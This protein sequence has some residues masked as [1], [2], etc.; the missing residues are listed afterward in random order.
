MSIS[1]TSLIQC[2]KTTLPAPSVPEVLVSLHQD[3]VVWKE[4]LNPEFLNKVCFQITVQENIQ[5]TD[6]SPARLALIALNQPLKAGINL[7]LLP[8]K[9]LDQSTHDY[10]N[11]VRNQ[12]EPDLAR[13]GVIALALA[14]RNRLTN[15]WSFLPDEIDQHT[16]FPWETPI[17]CLLGMI[18][19]PLS[20]LAALSSQQPSLLRSRLAIHAILSHPLERASQIDTLIAITNKPLSNFPILPLDMLDFLQILNEQA[21]DLASTFCQKI[22]AQKISSSHL[23]ISQPFRQSDILRETASTLLELEISRLAGDELR[24]DLHLEKLIAMR[25]M[26]AASLLAQTAS[27]RSLENNDPLSNAHLISDWNKMIELL[28]TVKPASIVEPFK[29][30][31]AR[32]LINAGNTTQAYSVLSSVIPG[33]SK[34]LFQLNALL[35]AAHKHGDEELTRQAGTQL[36]QI[37]NCNQLSQGYIAPH[38][39]VNPSQIANDLNNVG[40]S[41]NAMLVLEMALQQSP[42]QESWM[43]DLVELQISSSRFSEA[44]EIMQFLAGLHPKDINLR[45]RLAQMYEAY[46]NWSAALDEWISL[47]EDTRYSSQLEELDDLHALSSCALNAGRP[48]PAIHASQR[49][50]SLSNEDGL[51]YAF[52]GRAYAMKRDFVRGMEYVTQATQNSPNLSEGWLALADILAQQDQIHQAI[53]SLQTAN[54]I[55]PNNPRLLFSAGQLHYSCENLT[56]AADLIKQAVSLDPTNIH[57]HYTLGLAL[58]RLGH[59][60]DAIQELYRAY[61]ED[62]QNIDYASAYGAALLDAGNSHAALKPLT[63][64][65]QSKESATPTA[66]VNYARSVLNLHNDGNTEAKPSLALEAIKAALALDPHQPE[67]KGWYADALRTTGDLGA[68]FTI[69]QE[70]LETHLVH[71]RQWRERLSYGLGQTA[72]LLGRYDIAIASVQEAIATA[73]NNSKN[74]KLIAD[75]YLSSNLLED[76]LRAARTVLNLNTDNLVNLAWYA[77]HITRLVAHNKAWS[78]SG[79]QN[80]TKQALLEAQNALLQA[81]Q[82]APNRAELLIKLSKVQQ[83]AGNTQS[84]L[85]TMK[86]FINNNEE[87]SVEHLTAAADQMTSLGDIKGTIACLEKAVL[88]SLPAN[89]TTPDLFARLAKTYTGLGDLTSACN[90]LEQAI[91]IAPNVGSLYLERTN[92]LLT[93]GRIEDAFACVETGIS[94]ARTDPSLPRLYIMAACLYRL[95]GDL[96]SALAYIHKGL[97][98]YNGFEISQFNTSGVPL[99]DRLLVADLY[100]VGL[101]PLIAYQILKPEPESTGKDG[102]PTDKSIFEWIGLKMELELELGYT[103]DTQQ[104]KRIQVADSPPS[105]RWLAI[106]TRL[107][108]LQGTNDQANQYFQAAIQKELEEN[109]A[110]S[111]H[112]GLGRITSQRS[113]VSLF[114]AALDY[115]D[116]HLAQDILRRLSEIAPDEP[117]THLAEVRLLVRQAEFQQVCSQLEVQ[118]HAPGNEVISLANKEILDDAI[119]QISNL[120][121]LIEKNHPA[122]DLAHPITRLERWHSRGQIAFSQNNGDIGDPSLL[123]AAVARLKINSPEQT[124]TGEDAAAIISALDIRSRQGTEDNLLSEILQLARPHSRNPWVWLQAALSLESN[125]PREAFS[126]ARGAIQLF[127]CKESP[128]AVLNQALLA[129]IALRL[130]DITVAQGAIEAALHVWTDEPRWHV[131][132]AQIYQANLRPVEGRKHLEIAAHLDPQGMA[133]QLELGKAYLADNALDS[134]NITK[135]IQCFDTAIH[136]D[137]TEVT[138]WIW[139]ARAQLR[140]KQVGDAEKSVRQILALAPDNKDASVLQAEIA[141]LKKS[142]QVAHTFAQ[143]AVQSN[144]E[145][146]K[147]TLLLARTLKSLN[148]PTEALQVIESAL[149][150]SRDPLQLQYERAKY[151]HELHGP[152]AALQVLTE[153][154]AAY[155]DD[156]NIL[157][158]L[159]RSQADLGDLQAATDTALIALKAGKAKLEPEALARA[160]YLAGTLLR[161]SGQLDQAIQ[162]LNEAVSLAP[163]FLEAYLELGVTRKE[164]REYQ[165]ALVAFE[166]AVKIAPHDY[167]PHYQAGL[168]LKEGKDYRRSEIMLRQAA[169]LAPD[170]VLVRRQLAQVVAL[171]VV[172]NPRT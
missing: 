159:A 9:L 151:L 36:T 172:H 65:I 156:A 1:L 82:L 153:L 77:D 22:N 170:D 3:R 101:Q 69:Y 67:I 7:E 109:V 117:F 91:S 158:S 121:H 105:S 20:M 83:I 23:P 39:A 54:Q 43:K 49:A 51:A 5:V 10:I 25:N 130:N 35:L 29:A 103:P 16:T 149:P 139:L 110:K 66:Y 15:S 100:R 107:E 164:R 98:G 136:L 17:V 56:L 11:L 138:A 89:T 88:K 42:N 106:Q 111:S 75:A 92:L 32:A 73:P 131:L 38:A 59:T 171:N 61:Q 113:I 127:V 40:M 96:A 71:D 108:L 147:T 76:S 166:Q 168:A 135:A 150:I 47:N 21:P 8:A 34:D 128:S 72:Y 155:P 165:Q 132:A 44:A 41:S 161:R 148:R 154:V 87:A 140:A 104:Y 70:A 27:M 13:A 142:Y 123:S 6:W 134:M 129:R 90:T 19:E 74:H 114:E 31:Y 141:M 48:E 94:L 58:S 62:S 122:Y 169:I 84:A 78:S 50:I 64:A 30:G 95:N 68:A 167:R 137:T 45:H 125:Y 93:L 37:I 81:V 144:P 119:Q 12:E 2:L 152:D 79:I 97:E 157:A 33:D 112:N 28:E 4:L 80:Q 163:E 55:I 160:Y 85:E 143:S 18:Q 126:A 53:E 146:P 118:Q 24:Q 99:E 60:E 26:A 133:I 86:L 120:I 57:Y 102:S 63:F 162:H 124:Q 116:W 145:D 52:L 14:D 115:Q 46:Q